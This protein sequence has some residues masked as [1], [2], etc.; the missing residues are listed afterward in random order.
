MT[1]VIIQSNRESALLNSLNSSK[2]TSLEYS[3]NRNLPN[4]ARSI[5]KLTCP[6]S[7]SYTT[8]AVHGKEMNFTI[9]KLGYITGMYLES[10]V[11]TSAD[12]SAMDDT[13]LF[14]RMFS[15]IELRSST[16]KVLCTNEDSYIHCRIDTENSGKGKYYNY[17]TN[18]NVQFSNA[19]IT[20]YTPVFTSFFERL[21]NALDAEF[22]EQLYLRAVVNSANDML[23]TT[24]GATGLTGGGSF[25]LYLQYYNLAS[26]ASDTLK[27]QNFS[28][29]APTNMLCYDT[30]VEKFTASS[31][32]NTL[33]LNCSNCV[34]ATHIYPVETATGLP[35]AFNTSATGA[36]TPLFTLKMNG[37]S[38]FENIPPKMLL[39][40][41]C[42]QADAWGCTMVQVGSTGAQTSPVIK[43]AAT[44][45]R[46]M[47][48]YR[49]ITIVY[50]HMLADRCGNSGAVSMANTST[51]QLIISQC[52]TLS[53]HTIRVVHEYWKLIAI[54]G[55]N[56]RIESFLS[57]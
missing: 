37:K 7:T 5:V 18:S 32:T 35:V 44:Y 42:L 55:A 25:Y 46:S 13:G 24:L 40:D 3:L 31:T 21:E 19:T 11:V 28:L 16:G 27:A 47:H 34:F 30:Y 20:G 41:K 48:Q 52:G 51:P 38:V 26:E 4:L 1:D 57:T 33:T 15:V 22:C 14:E 29:S 45:L 12:F 56:G 2:T 53:G 49:P 10:T 54:S 17:I 36:T 43:S 23:G 50:G 6:T 8:T 9:P 39:A